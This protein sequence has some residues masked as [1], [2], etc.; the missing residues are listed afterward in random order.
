M[1]SMFYEFANNQYTWQPK[2][3]FAIRAGVES[4]Q[5]FADENPEIASIAG[6]ITAFFILS[7]VI[8]R[9]D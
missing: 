4:L 6:V 9:G 7:R 5:R 3:E 8:A 2:I 1:E